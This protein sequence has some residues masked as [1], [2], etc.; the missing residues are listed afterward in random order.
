MN[1][2]QEF[3]IE[4]KQQQYDY[5]SKMAKKYDLPDA[6]KAARCLINYA[7]EQADEEQSI[8]SQIRCMDC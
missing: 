1:G 4:L 8:F 6:S 2:N 3:T 5:L 7:I